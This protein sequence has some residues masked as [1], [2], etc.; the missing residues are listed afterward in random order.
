MKNAKEH[1][2]KENNNLISA[3]RVLRSAATAII[4]V[5]FS[6][7]QVSA[8]QPDYYITVDGTI[9]IQGK[10]NE[11]PLMAKSNKVT[12]L[13]NYN[14]GDFT[15]YFDASTLKTGVMALD[16]VLLKQ[17]GYVIQYEGKFGVDHVQTES[18]APLNFMVEGYINCH[19]HNDYIQGKGRLEHLYDDHYSCYLNMSFDLTLDQLPFKIEVERLDEHIR[20]EI[21]QMVMNQNNSSNHSNY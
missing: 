19:Y 3:L 12:V 4:V 8:Q 7:C 21:V 10:L 15:M 11:Q 2:K 1:W 5:A 18:H 9:M 16:T 14:T 6:V 17:K 20:V 13:V